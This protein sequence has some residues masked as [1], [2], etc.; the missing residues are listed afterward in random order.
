MRVEDWQ[1]AVKTPKGKRGRQPG[2]KIEKREKVEKLIPDPVLAKKS[3]FEPTKG[4]SVEIQRR[5]MASGSCGCGHMSII[6]PAGYCP[7]KLTGTDRETVF[8]WAEKVVDAGHKIAR[9][10]TMKAVKYYA[11][12]FFDCYDPEDAIKLRTIME[13][14]VSIDSVGSVST[15]QFGECGQVEDDEELDQDE[16]DE[17]DSNDLEEEPLD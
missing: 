17:E 10:F 1:I 5:R 15:C 7:V 8:K 4:V 13:H 2:Q 3:E 14:L 12:E 16:L 9:H 6:A 11:R